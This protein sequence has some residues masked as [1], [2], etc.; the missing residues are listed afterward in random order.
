MSSPVS[1]LRVFSSVFLYSLLH[2]F[3]WYITLIFSFLNAFCLYFF[4]RKIYSRFRFPTDRLL[5]VFER[6]GFFTFKNPNALFI[7][8]YFII[9][10]SITL[11]SLYFLGFLPF[12]IFSYIYIYIWFIVLNI[13]VLCDTALMC[14]CCFCKFRLITFHLLLFFQIWSACFNFSFEI[15]YFLSSWL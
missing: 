10:P 2:R 11:P 15:F 1:P 13:V 6:L 7:L 4:S 14:F 5:L 9:F 8:F 12:P 3:Y